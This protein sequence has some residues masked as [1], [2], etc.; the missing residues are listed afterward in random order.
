M[1]DNHICIPFNTF[2][3]CDD[4]SSYKNKYGPETL[5]HIC[6]GC[7]AKDES[8]KQHCVADC[9]VA[10]FVSLFPKWYGRAVALPAFSS[11]PSSLTQFGH[12]S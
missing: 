8:K 7:L 6:G 12:H 11:H 3:G 2:K 1:K 10:N 9:K 5:Q 4:Q